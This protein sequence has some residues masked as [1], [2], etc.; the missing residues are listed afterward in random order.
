MPCGNFTRIHFDAVLAKPLRVA[1]RGPLAGV[2]RVIGDADTLDVL[3]RFPQ[4]IGE[5]L[6]AKQARHVLEP[7][8]P[9]GQR[10]KHRLAQDDFRGVPNAFGIEQARDAGRA[11][12]DAWARWASVLPWR[13]P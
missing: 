10:V 9:K 13:R 5:A 8:R 6:R 7:R 2:V 1:L 12:T 11:D 3:D 4:F